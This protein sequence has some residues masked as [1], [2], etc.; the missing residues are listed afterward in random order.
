MNFKQV[1]LSLFVVIVSSSC[2]ATKNKN[3]T[4]NQTYAAI[5]VKEDIVLLKKIL[6]ANHPSLYWY[7]P[8]DSIDFYFAQAIISLKDSLTELQAKNKIAA[9]ISKMNIS[10]VIDVSSVELFA[11]DG[12]TVMTSIFF[13]NKEYNKI[14][15]QSPDNVLIKKLEYIN[16]KSIWK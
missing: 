4:F 3:Y 9:I 11:D 8:K 1:L 16:L 5:K 7:T 10:L 15:I 12:L 2:V 14:H 6:E 13:P